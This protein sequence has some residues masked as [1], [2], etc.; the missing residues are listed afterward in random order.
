LLARCWRELAAAAARSLADGSALMQWHMFCASAVVLVLV[1]MINKVVAGAV[2]CRELLAVC[3]RF[4]RLRS[5]MH[6]RQKQPINRKNKVK[7]IP[8]KELIRAPR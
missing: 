3:A 6:S 1:L 8:R 7:K 2:N 4:C 5:S